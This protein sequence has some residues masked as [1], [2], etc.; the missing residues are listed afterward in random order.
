MMTLPVHLPVSYDP[1]L[2][3]LGHAVRSN[4]PGPHSALASV[5]KGQIYLYMQVIAR[6]YV[7]VLWIRYKGITAVGISR[8][9]WVPVQRL[10]LSQITKMLSTSVV[11]FLV[12]EYQDPNYVL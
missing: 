11:T 10:V 9:H 5:V 8:A 12:T 3:E 7:S 4:G 1:L 6:S 2:R